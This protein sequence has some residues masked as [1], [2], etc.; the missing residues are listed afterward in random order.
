MQP[1]SEVRKGVWLMCALGIIALSICLVE[2]ADRHLH[3]TN[4]VLVAAKESMVRM[5]TFH[6]HQSGSSLSKENEQVSG[7]G[8]S[9][10]IAF[11]VLL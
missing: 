4:H 2:Q 7:L 8:G 5:L 1:L 6:V 11:P 3:P 9:A 10:F